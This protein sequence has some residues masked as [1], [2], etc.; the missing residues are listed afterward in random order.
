MTDQMNAGLL[1]LFDILD[2][3]FVAFECMAYESIVNI[4]ET[5]AHTA[6]IKG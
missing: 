3:S 1:Y 6:T 4:P 2:G 5:E